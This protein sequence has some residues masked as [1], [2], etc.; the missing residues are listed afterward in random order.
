MSS[1]ADHVHSNGNTI[2]KSCNH[3]SIYK[4]MFSFKIESVPLI[5]LIFF[6]RKC[7]SKTLAYVCVCACVYKMFPLIQHIVL[8]FRFR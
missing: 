3:G 4:V 7:A 5:M 6:S 2:P 1:H 8:S